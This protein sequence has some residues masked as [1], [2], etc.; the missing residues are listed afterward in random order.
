[1]T[2][3]R[4]GLCL[5][6]AAAGL[7][8]AGCGEGGNDMVG[9]VSPAEATQLNDAAEMLDASADGLAAPEGEPVDTESES[10]N[11]ADANSG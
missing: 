8:V 9:G 3:N 7:L 2:M 5:L 11:A 10:G 6:V 4:P 1:M